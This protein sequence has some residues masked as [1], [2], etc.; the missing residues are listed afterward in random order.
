MG[1]LHFLGLETRNGSVGSAGGTS[2]LPGVIPP[3]RSNVTDVT[4]DGA[5]TIPAVYRSF[6]ILSNA[7]SQL[8]L[9]VYRNDE[10]IPTPGVIKRP[11]VDQSLSEFLKRTVIG[12]AASGNAYW[13]IYRNPD[14]SLSSL[15]VLNPL[16]ISIRYDDKGRKFYDY[17]DAFQGPSQTFNDRQVSHLRLLPV[18]GHPYGLGPIQA[19]R[20]ALSGSLD[21][22]RY[23]DQWFQTGAV[24]TGILSSD[25]QLTPVDAEAIRAR[26][27]ELQGERDVAILGKGLSYSPIV[28]NPADAQFLESRQFSV[29]DIA[30]IFGVPASYLL[31]EVNGSSMTYSNLEQVD[32]AFV[33]Y[34]LMGYLKPIEDA[35]SD[36]LVRGQI[37]RF[38]LDGLLR[39][40]AKTQAEIHEKYLALG[41]MTVNEVRAAKGWSPIPGGD[42]VKAIPSDTPSNT[43]NEV[44]A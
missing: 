15:Q 43:T 37:A 42:Q 28:L 40:D 34:C 2:P 29:T 38:K 39:P 23:S 10:E 1:F 25:Q 4:V 31:A 5:L 24:P 7:V 41:V 14:G 18:P 33:R 21:L 6:A 36:V 32:T 35:L 19:C 20:Q 22:A 44:S 3:S 17:S 12:L 13:R 26:W 27:H 9:G 30:R 8:E 11:D 16:G